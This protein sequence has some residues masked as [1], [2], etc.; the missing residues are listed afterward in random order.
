MDIDVKN[1]RTSHKRHPY[2]AIVQ[3]YKNS[4]YRD[5]RVMAPGDPG[6]LLERPAREVC[7][8]PRNEP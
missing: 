1:H 7:A 4:Q 5:R 3:S 2:T 6:R 8:R